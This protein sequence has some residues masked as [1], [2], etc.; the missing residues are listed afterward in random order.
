[1]HPSLLWIVLLA[2]PLP[3]LSADTG[4]EMTVRRTT[5]GN[6]YEQKQY[7][8]SDRK[9]VEFRNQ[10]GRPKADGSMEMLSGPAIAAITRCDLGAMFELNLEAREYTSAP[11]PPKPFTRR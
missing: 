2:V 1:M 8:L 11:Y 9:R 10:S 7:F 4:F 6:T 3:Q 5:H